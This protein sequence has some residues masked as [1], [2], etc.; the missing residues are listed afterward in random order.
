[1]N[2]DPVW[3]IIALF[4]SVFINLG[5][6]ICFLYTKLDEA[7]T[8]LYDVYFIC[9]YKS[10]FGT[11]LAGRQ[12]RMNALSMVVLIPG[13]LEK[14]GEM[15]REAYLR[16]PASLIKQVRVLYIFLYANGLAMAGLYFFF[17]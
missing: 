6:M 16:L 2:I 15:S 4:I 17:S 12:A 10:T 3:W 9:W 13:L 5:L 14:R 7:E 1:M 8:L 11:S